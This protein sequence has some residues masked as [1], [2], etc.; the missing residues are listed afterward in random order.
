M[1]GKRSHD[2]IGNTSET[3]RMSKSKTEPTILDQEFRCL[4]EAM[5]FEIENSEFRNKC[6]LLLFALKGPLVQPN[7]VHLSQALLNLAET[8]FDKQFLNACF[9]R[10]RLQIGPFVKAR[11]VTVHQ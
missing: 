5:L 2:F 11:A 9:S 7:A 8:L 1:P 10:Q 4:E 3:R 6:C